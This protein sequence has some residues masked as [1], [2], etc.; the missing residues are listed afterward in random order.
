MARISLSRNRAMTARSV[1]WAG[2]DQ[3]IAAK[4]AMARAAPHSPSRGE[5]GGPGILDV[6]TL[7]AP[8]FRASALSKFPLDQFDQ[9][10]YRFGYLGT[11]R[12]GVQKAAQRCLSLIFP[13]SAPVEDS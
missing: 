12:P 7:P 8:P 10:Y 6:G 11:M 5:V 3:S 1:N 13:V 9:M 2:P 4:T